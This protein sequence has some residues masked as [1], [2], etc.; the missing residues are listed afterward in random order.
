MTLYLGPPYAAVLAWLVLGEPIHAYHAVGL[1]L[2][3]PGVW[4]VNRAQAR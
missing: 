3:L 4:L 1:L 2:I